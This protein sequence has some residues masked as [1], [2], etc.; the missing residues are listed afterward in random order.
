M[1]G[2]TALN[3]SANGLIK[4]SG[5]FR[6]M[7]VQPAAGDDGAALGA[8]LHVAVAHETGNVEPKRM[9]LPLY[10]PEF[11]RAEVE[12]ALAD[13]TEIGVQRIESVAALSDEVA[14]RICEGQ[15]VGWFQG[16]MEFG[17]RAL[18]NRS[19]LADPRDPKMRERI[20]TLVKK[21]EEFRPFAPVVRSEAAGRYFEI[22]PGDEQEHSHMLIVTQV[23][24]VARAQLPAVTHVDGSA[25]VQTVTRLQNRRL[26]ELLGAF[27]RICGVPVL[28]NTSFNLKGQ[29]I[30]C[31]PAEALDTFLVA[32]L[33]ALVIGDFLITPA[34]DGSWK[35]AA[36]TARSRIIL[37]VG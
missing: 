16:R 37:G 3:C 13:R 1:A 25:R 23:R 33:D 4:R 22:R 12:Q 9:G 29:P 31:T 5:L 11:S 10:G 8:A 24:P 2:G 28:L 19:I 14:R 26:W 20:N 15:I 32:G 6:R 21:R 35:A 7:F 17:P 27:E 18:G 36:V 34:A 30:V